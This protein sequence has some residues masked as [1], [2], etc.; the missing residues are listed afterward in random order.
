MKIIKYTARKSLSSAIVALLVASP[1]CALAEESKD[2]DLRAAVQ[3]PISSLVS[4]PFKFTFDF[5]A[6]NGD[7]SI[8]NIQPVVPVT[9][10]N[11]NLVNRAI[12][13]IIDSPGPVAGIPSNP[14]PA[15]GNGA[16]GLG[17]INYSLY[18]SPVDYGKVIWGVGP[19]ITLKTATDDQLGSGKW[20]AGASAIAL[21]QPS[22]G[23]VG[24]LGRQLWS[25]A[26]DDD[27]ADVSQFLLE[28]FANY[29]LSNGWFLITDMVA[30]ANWEAASGQVWTVP[31][32]GGA[33]RV[34]KIGNQAINSRL[35]AYYNV[36][37]PDA[38]PDWSVSF[39]FQFLFPR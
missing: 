33:G 5:G 36:I 28:P 25:F 6:T 8:L 19:S 30:T 22:W 38:A 14:S 18:F 11:W 26:G 24:I 2:G 13:P 10:G 32:G 4:L 9:V 21:T 27:R 35:E 29:N 37:N 17:D 16:T 15:P 39:T 31:I 7:A 20:S 34:F 12:I 23:S 3:N 1:F